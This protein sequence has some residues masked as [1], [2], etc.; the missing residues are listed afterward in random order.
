[1]KNRLFCVALAVMWAGLF[2]G[3][4]DAKLCSMPFVGYVETLEQNLN[5]AYQ[6]FRNGEKESVSKE[7]EVRNGD[8]IRPVPGKEATLIY[9]HTGCKKEVITKNTKVS[10]YPPSP[11]KDKEPWLVSDMIQGFRKLLE[12][13]KYEKIIYLLRF[14]FSII[15]MLEI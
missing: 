1:M 8:E 4:D 12:E 2:I 13:K 7:T 6:L 14:N 15:K 10:C 11:V 5:E 9:Y 3:A